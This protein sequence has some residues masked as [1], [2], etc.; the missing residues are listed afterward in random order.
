[1]TVVRLP[2]SIE[3]IVSLPILCTVTLGDC[4]VGASEAELLADAALALAGLLGVLPAVVLA[5]GLL[6]GVALAGVV[7]GAVVLAEVVL[8]G[9]VPGAVVLAGVVLAGV[10]LGAVVLAG[11]GA[12]VG[13]LSSRTE[14]TG[15]WPG[16]S[17]MT[18]V[19]EPSSIDMIVCLPTVWTSTLGD[20]G[21]GAGVEEADPAAD[22]WLVLS[23]GGDGSAAAVPAGVAGEAPLLEPDTACASCGRSLRASVRWLSAWS[24]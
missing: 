9:V 15:F 17:T 1:M 12:V 10:V 2:L 11:D 16:L 8:A 6:A 22:D 5:G 13:L 23:G 19:C 24:G 7:P 18:V 14:T 3:V 4:G 21:V 20:C